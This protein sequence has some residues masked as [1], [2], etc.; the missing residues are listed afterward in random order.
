MDIATFDEAPADAAAALLRACADVDAW[1][2]TLV[3]ERPFGSVEALLGRADVLAGDWTPDQVDAALADHP[4][5][6]ERHAGAGTSAAL[7]GREQS[8]V[9]TSTE[10]AARLAAG[11]AAYEERFGRVFLVRAAGRGTGEILALLEQRL[12]HDPDT[13]LAVTA[14]QLREIAVLRLKGLLT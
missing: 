6:G 7:S 5:I 4:R 14:Q 3:A 12:T 11:N 2:E 1:V 9:D 10:T 13:E 8:G